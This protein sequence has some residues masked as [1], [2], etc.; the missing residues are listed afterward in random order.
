MQVLTMM[1]LCLHGNI[2]GNFFLPQKCR[3]LEKSAWL[4]PRMPTLL[5]TVF[6]AYF[7]QPA[8]KD[9]LPALD[10]DLVTSQAHC[11]TYSK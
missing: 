9:S 4:I 7:C 11:I 10:P 8:A 2:E 5:C 6:L 1:N 3:Q